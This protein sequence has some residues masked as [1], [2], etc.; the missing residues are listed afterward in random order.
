MSRAS[1]GSKWAQAAEAAE[2]GKSRW[3]D[4]SRYNDTEFLDYETK[5]IQGE[6][7]H[8]SR[9]AL[10]R[11]NETEQMAS[12][13][14]NSLNQQSEQ[15]YRMEKKLDE[16]EIRAKA[17]ATKVDSL[18]S[19]NRFFMMPTFGAAKKAQ[20]AQEKMEKELQEQRANHKHS[21][22][23][24]SDWEQ[25][26]E[27]QRRYQD[28]MGRHGG[29]SDMYTTPQ[30]LERDEYEEEIDSNL[31]QLSSGLSRLKMMGQAMNDELDS[32]S[33]QLHRISDRTDT[34]RDHVGRLNQK[35]TAFDK[36]RR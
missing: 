11:L 15:L 13:S 19:L 7:V 2:S 25:R 10:S 3:M 12:N 8:S 36:K 5:R 1:Q 14:M 4:D 16:T 30:G 33:S 6:S 23:R 27:R 21:K 9:R 26:Q 22:Q 20:N 34:A 29:R 28:D 31:N 24:E 35:M 17:N 18:K 32:Q